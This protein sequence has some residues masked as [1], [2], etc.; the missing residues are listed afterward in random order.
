[1]VANSVVSNRQARLATKAYLKKKLGLVLTEAEERA[2]TPPSAAEMV[3][4]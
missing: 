1:M 3:T 4:A 2:I